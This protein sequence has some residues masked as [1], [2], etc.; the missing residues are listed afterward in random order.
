MGALRVNMEFTWCDKLPVFRWIGLFVLLVLSLSGCAP[1]VTQ[2]QSLTTTYAVLNSGTT[3]GQTFVATHA[4]LSGMEFDFEPLNPGTGEV[5]LHLRRAPDARKDITTARLSIDAVEAPGPYRF[6]FQ[7]IE[8][9]RR[10]SYYAFLEIE[11]EGS[12][13]VGVAWGYTYLDGSFY[14]DHQPY[15]AQMAFSMIFDRTQAFLGV[16]HQVVS[17]LGILLMGIF[18]FV[19]PGWGVLRSVWPQWAR[20][21]WIEKMALS[22]GLSLA[23]IPLLFLWTDVFGLH[24]G[25][26]YAWLPGSVSLVPLL[27]LN[28]QTIKSF[29]M[30]WPC[31]HEWGRWISDHLPD[32]TFLVVIAL[33]FAVR[34]W[35]VSNLDLPMWGDSYQHTVLT[36]LLLN[37]GGLFDSWEPYA[38]LQSLTYHFGFHADTAVFGWLANLPA[39]R[40]I[41]WTGQLFNTLAVL[42]V[43]PLA[44][45]LGGNRW[46]G[47][48]AVLLAGL[49]FPMP[50]SYVNW[51]RYTQLAGQTILPVFALLYWDTMR[52]EKRDWKNILVLSLLLSGLALTH[53]RILIFAFALIPAY[54]ILEV[55][56]KTFLPWFVHMAGLG[57]GSALLFLPWFIHVF[58]ARIMKILENQLTTVPAANPAGLDQYN[59]I[60]DIFT[61]APAWAWLL[62]PLMIGAGLWLRKKD[63]ALLASWWFLILLT[64]NPAWLN[65]PGTGTVSNFAVFIAAYIPISIFLGAGVGWLGEK[66]LHRPRTAI[67]LPRLVLGVM[68]IVAAVLGGRQRLADVRIQ[69]FAL[70][71]RSDLTAAAWIRENTPADAKFVVNYFFAYLDQLI[72]GADGG[73]WLPLLTE[74]QSN[75]PPL[76]YGIEDSSGDTYLYRTNELASLIQKDGITSPSVIRQLIDE[77]FEYIYI[78]QRQG[79]VNNPGPVVLDP[80][81][82]KLDE[83]FQLLYQRDRVWIFKLTP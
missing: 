18:L 54:F 76:T 1:I 53:Y 50:M 72:V 40:A 12:L 28:R 20:F 69:D 66:W 39:T 21:D 11:G 4:G 82:L 2:S 38:P 49:C 26:G 68:I 62:L 29:K 6:Y 78:G 43:Y 57:L 42:A 77:G 55:R 7:T 61:Y 17:W 45:R 74:R 56:R 10:Q 73:W 71:T 64:A 81:V 47:I 9:S 41:I 44:V 59:S 27:W 31:K 79:A 60:G 58:G 22:A 65:L 52:Q 83:H 5:I 75:L 48:A 36:Q 19:L 32:F 63:V 67:W 51:G 33:V 30:S 70:A 35:S 8:D 14:Q 15:D 24:L 34:F 13:Q 3:L 16:L 23:I 25:I 80:Q 46:A 37:Q